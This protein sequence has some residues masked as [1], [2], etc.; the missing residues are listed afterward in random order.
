MSSDVHRLQLAE[1]AAALRSAVLRAGPQAPVPTCPDWDVLGM[2]RHLTKVYAMVREALTMSPGDSRPAPAS[3]PKEFDALLTEW[4]A[5]LAGL[6]EELAAAPQN[7]P[8]WSFFPGGTPE[9]WTRRMAHETAIHR[10]DAEH[11]VAETGSGHP[12]ELL[13]DPE[14]AADGVDEFLT[15]ILGVTG[16]WTNRSDNGELLFHAADAGRTWQVS[17]RPEQRPQVHRPHDAALGTP[18][19]DATVAGTADAVYRRVW[20]RPSSAMITGTTEL[21]ELVHGR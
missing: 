14:F 8:V 7:R 19:V 13:F 4:D 20:G 5:G 12:P 10:L 16:D 9:T 21:A 6:L 3:P 2:L 18:Q 11:A 15:L 1:Q 17:F